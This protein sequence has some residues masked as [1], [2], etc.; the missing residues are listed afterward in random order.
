M[1]GKRKETIVENIPNL[2]EVKKLQIQEAQHFPKRIN[3]KKL[4]LHI[5][6]NYWKPKTKKKFLTAAR[7]KW[8]TPQRGI[9]FK[10]PKISHRKSEIKTQ[11]GS[12]IKLLK[13]NKCLLRILYPPK[14]SFKNESK[15]KTFSD[16]EKQ[17]VYSQQTAL[18]EM[19]K[20]WAERK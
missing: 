20:H 15:I 19:L 14:I 9:R 6:P 13:G 2:V 3:S 5:K 10:L 12:I 16:K 17:R 11:W 7:E 8:H 1:E 4:T 18:Q